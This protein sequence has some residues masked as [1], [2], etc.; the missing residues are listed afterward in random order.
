VLLRVL[1]LLLATAVGQAAST[2]IQN[3]DSSVEV[4]LDQY[5]RAEY[6]KATSSLQPDNLESFADALAAKGP[7]WVRAADPA[8]E[9]R[10]RLVE[11]SLALEAVQRALATAPSF[12]HQVT[13]ARLIEWGSEQLQTTSKADRAWYVASIA[14]A[15]RITLHPFLAGIEGYHP[16][17]ASEERQRFGNALAY[18]ASV[19]KRIPDEPRVRLAV[20]ALEDLAPPANDVGWMSHPPDLA[21]SFMKPFA[22]EYERTIRALT[23]AASTDSI[24]AEAHLRAAVIEWRFG[25]PDAAIAH[26]D[27]VEPSTADPYLIYLSRFVRGKALEMQGRAGDAEAAYRSALSVVPDAESAATALA[28]SLFLR[29]EKTE[30]FSLTQRGLAAAPVT[31]DPWRQYRWGDYRMAPV[32]METLRAALR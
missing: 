24:R 5:G 31:A 23:E 10:R 8:Q 15:E 22:A 9:N 13:S 32:Q 27:Q 29:G 4:L 7:S 30:A 21:G 17:R 25:R 12:A 3:A 26:L 20:A 11:A 6:E 2:Q 19:Q 16:S 18:I 14:L 28:T 1:P